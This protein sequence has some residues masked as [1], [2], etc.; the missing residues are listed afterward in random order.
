MGNYA[1]VLV[2][3]AAK[4][5]DHAT[6]DLP[7]EYATGRMDVFVNGKQV[8][9]N[10]EYTGAFPGRF[11]IKGRGLERSYELLIVHCEGYPFTIDH[12]LQYQWPS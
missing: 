2:F 10:G 1:D 3:D 5:T 7:Q 8:L 11:I 4:I 6:Y 9:K 12:S